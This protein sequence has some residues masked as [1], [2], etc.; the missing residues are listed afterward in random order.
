MFRSV[1]RMSLSRSA[2]PG[3]C[4]A[5]VPLVQDRAY[6]EVHVVEVGQQIGTLLLV[7]V[8]AQGPEDHLQQK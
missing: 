6:W 4:L 8:A 2:G 1:F 5:A 7:G 3:R